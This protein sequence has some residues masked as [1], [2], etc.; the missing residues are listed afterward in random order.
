MIFTPEFFI[1]SKVVPNL[2]LQIYWLHGVWRCKCLFRCRLHLTNQEGNPGSCWYNFLLTQIYIGLNKSHFHWN[3]NLYFK[4]ISQNAILG[5]QHN[6]GVLSHSSIQENTNRFTQPI[7]HFLPFKSA[8]NSVRNNF[9]RQP[10]RPSTFSS[11]S[12]LTTDADMAFQQVG[13]RVP[14]RLYNDPFS[15]E[16]HNFNSM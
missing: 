7:S 12:F 6:Q 16:D 11:N 9:D 4:F 14:E 3:K 1:R 15:L 5:T 13:N 10:S 2:L 8:G